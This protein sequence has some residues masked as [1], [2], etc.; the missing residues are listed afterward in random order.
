M[1]NATPFGDGRDGAGRFAKGNPGGPGNPHGG[2]VA[3]LRAKLLEA[4]TDADFEAIARSLVDR[5][6]AAEPWAVKEVLDR[7]IGKPAVS[8]TVEADHGSG[9]VVHYVVKPPR[10]LNEGE[11]GEYQKGV[12]ETAPRGAV[13]VDSALRDSV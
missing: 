4:I 1:T 9:R 10:L 12:D 3:A 7:I 5:A 13:L 8:V 11:R 2:R 6:K